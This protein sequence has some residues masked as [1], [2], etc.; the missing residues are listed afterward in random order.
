MDRLEIFEPA[1][2]CSSGVCGTNVDQRLVQFTADLDWLKSRGV[3]VERYNLAQQPD[4]FVQSEPV[5]N[6]M[7]LADDKC[8]PIILADGRIVAQNTYPDRSTLARLAGLTTE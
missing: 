5:K 4:K 6:A 2:C 7:A 1:M 8:L 3:K